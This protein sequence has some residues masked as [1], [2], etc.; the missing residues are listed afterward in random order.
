MNRIGSHQQI[1][2]DYAA[3]VPTISVYSNINWEI[4]THIQKTI[5]SGQSYTE[6][7]RNP[8]ACVPFKTLIN[9]EEYP[10]WC[11]KSKVN[12]RVLYVLHF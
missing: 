5:Y 9:I 6:Q 7:H 8:K 4:P 3:V 12:K 1:T 11:D 10:A 2:I